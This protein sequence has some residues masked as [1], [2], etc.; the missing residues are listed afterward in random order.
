M[1]IHVLGLPHT[2]TTEEFTTCAFTQKA[3]NLCKM[4]HRRGHEVIHYGVEG[5][6]PE[7]TEN[8]SVMPQKTWLKEIG[9]HPGTSFYNIEQGGKLA[10]YHALFA[11]NMHAELH[12]RSGP[13]FTEIIC[14]PWGGAQVTACQGIDQYQVESGIG[15]PN[16]WAEWRVYESYAWM[17]MHL[18]RDQLF[19]GK[20]WYWAVI[21]NAFNLAN[22]TPVEKRGEDFLYLGRLNDDKGVLIAIQAA[23]EAGRKITIVGQ[24][25]PVPFL[26]GNPNASYL[27]PVGVEERRKLLAEAY[28]VFCPTQF[29]EPFCGVNVEA[30]LSGTPVITSDFGVFPET[31]IHGVTGY[32]CRSFEQFVWA[33]KNV[34][35]LKGSDCSDWARAN[36]SLERVA[37]MYEEFFQQIL[38]VRD[39]HK[40]AVGPTGFYERHPGR[41]QL[42]WLVRVYPKAA[43]ENTLDLNRPHESPVVPV[44]PQAAPP[45]HLG[46]A[47]MDRPDPAT[48]M[49]DI[50]ERLIAE[51]GIRSAIDVGAG[52][53]FTT[54]WLFDRLGDA[55]G[56]EGD[57]SAHAVKQCDGLVQHDYASGPYRPAR[58]FD[59][60]WSAEF[61][62]HVE[63]QYIPNWM[64][65]LA[66]CKFVVITFAT[67]GQGGHHHVTER[68]ESFWIERFAAH[69]LEHV[70]EETARLRATSNGEPYGRKTLTFFRNTR[71]ADDKS[72]P[73]IASVGAV[74]RHPDRTQAK[75]ETPVI[76]FVMRVHNEA[77]TL[78]SS[79]I[80]LLKIAIPI[81]VVVVLHRC[82]DESKAIALACQEGA[83]PRHRMKIV[84]YATPIS[85][86]GLE[87]YITPS[88]SRHSLMS[89]Y[90][91]AFGLASSPWKFKWD[92]DCIAPGV[93]IKWIEGRDWRTTEPTIINVTARWTGSD[94]VSREPYMHNCL[95]R[96][97]KFNFWEVPVFPDSVAYENAPPDAHFLRVGRDNLK[98]YWRDPPWF[99][100][101]SQPTPA[102]T[103]E[104]AVLRARYALAVELVG[105][106]PLGCA[107]SCN[108]NAATYLQ[109]C[110][111]VRDK[112]S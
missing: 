53:G 27:P 64:A 79:I 62:E 104:A 88:E 35:R 41:T 42:D 47:Y 109:K 10:P 20:K 97:D 76:S 91:F 112:L 103:S 14:Q 57:P 102:Q 31:V 107:R 8:V 40:T 4:L 28:A 68:D 30:Q 101:H 61:V 86:A 50:W 21:P 65:T 7:C 51:Y 90:N 29:V 93:F 39:H 23:K 94:V 100:S 19:G 38:N 105:P 56:V 36:Y 106:E 108:P 37:P 45:P 9:G 99:A 81:E 15:Y 98:S 74:E 1:R 49:P 43:T 32:R 111:A 25:N 60:G 54:R 72:E 26:A 33:A 11:K 6:N 84:E 92:G 24:G 82:T 48:W 55:V 96:F 77:G 22:F 5:S 69:G 95:Q 67:P 59:L 110:E 3:L 80:S 18:G 58:T 89:Y 71:L 44:P 46:G 78:R 66:R 52:A 73:S 34:D 85:R 63:E 16:S 70:P 17:H 2:Q 13:R 12:K 87:T 83:P 75:A